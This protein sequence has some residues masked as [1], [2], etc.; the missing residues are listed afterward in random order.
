MRCCFPGRPGLAWCPAYTCLFMVRMPGQHI[1][2]SAAARPRL[3]C[4]QDLA[5]L[6]AR[7][8]R[9]MGVRRE[10]VEAI[11][12]VDRPISCVDRPTVE[13]AHHKS[14]FTG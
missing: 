8:C 4:P 2:W 3:A 14:R 10:Q 5:Q 9:N 6:Q 13:K 11:S 7:C 1:R 12:C